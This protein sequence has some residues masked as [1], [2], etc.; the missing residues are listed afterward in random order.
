MAA[1][2]EHRGVRVAC[3][4]LRS[5]V[6]DQR[7]DRM[8]RFVAAAAAAAEGEALVLIGF[9]GA[10]VMLPNIATELGTRVQTTVFIDAV[11]PPRRGHHELGTEFAAFIDGH[12]SHG[13]LAPWLDWWP[14]EVPKLLPDA[15]LRARIAADMPQVPR[16]FYDEQLDV[17]E[18]W[19]DTDH[20]YLQTSVAYETDR[21]LAASFGW[22]TARLDGTHLSIATDPT[23]VL[24]ALDRLLA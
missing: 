9:S 21:S 6:T 23:S 19:V 2:L 1:Q 12:T 13:L 14:H 18:N 22:P 10:G 24:D 20:R 17:A 16:A 7:D 8:Q 4:D 3:P 5:A 15:T 11:V